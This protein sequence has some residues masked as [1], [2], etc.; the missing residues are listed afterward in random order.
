MI[1]EKR[2]LLRILNTVM[3]SP[4]SGGATVSTRHGRLTTRRP[5]QT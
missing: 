4:H 5:P 3:S 2:G 1:F